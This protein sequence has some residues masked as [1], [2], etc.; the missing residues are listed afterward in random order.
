MAYKIRSCIVL[1]DAFAKNLCCEQTSQLYYFYMF[2]YIQCR[3]HR[4]TDQLHL[5]LT[6]SFQSFPSQQTSLSWTSS[7]FLSSLLF[8]QLNLRISGHKDYCLYKNA[9]KIDAV[10]FKFEDNGSKII[11]RFTIKKHYTR[12]KNE[13]KISFVLRIKL[14]FPLTSL[15]LEKCSFLSYFRLIND[16]STFIVGI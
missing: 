7:W 1:K 11:I 5:K 8:Q 16:F 2:V 4:P 14:L 9:I 13:R 15:S 12:A 10:Q 3:R 6:F